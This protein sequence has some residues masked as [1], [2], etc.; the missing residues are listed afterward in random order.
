MAYLR[1]LVGFF[2]WEESGGQRLGNCGDSN[3]EILNRFVSQLKVSPNTAARKTSVILS[4]CRHYEIPV[5]GFARPILPKDHLHI[6]DPE[7][8]DRMLADSRVSLRTKALLALM[9]YEGKRTPAI[10]TMRIGS[11][12]QPGPLDEAEHHLRNYLASRPQGRT[13]YVFL[14]YTNQPISRQLVWKDIKE[15]SQWFPGILT[16]ASIR[17]SWV[18]RYSRAGF[19]EADIAKIAGLTAQTVT[20]II[21]GFRKVKNG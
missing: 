4:F 11:K 5:I 7:Q 13:Q 20:H 18:I 14:G 12:R 16:P 6:I 10:V 19:S 21:D 2:T 1:D 8:V 9:T 15:L 17:A 3:A